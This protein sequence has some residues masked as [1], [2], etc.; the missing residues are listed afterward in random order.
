MAESIHPE[1]ES[2]AVFDHVRPIGDGSTARE[3]QP[4]V[5]RVVGTPEDVVTLL[6]VADAE[7]CR[8]T[9][10]E[11]HSVPR[12]DLDSLEP[13]GNPDENQSLA[14]MLTSQLDGLAW[15][16]RLMGRTVVERPVPGTVSLGLVAVGLV[17]DPFFPIPDHVDAMLFLVGVLSLFYLTKTT[18]VR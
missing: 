14:A 9:T 10:G 1:M 7:G 4:G 2:V 3:L 13:A 17:G 16:L 8:V 12:T 5:Y 15:Q 11:L 6:R 18:D